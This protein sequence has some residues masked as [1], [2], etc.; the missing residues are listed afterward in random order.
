MQDKK[1][2]ETFLSEYEILCR[3]YQLIIDSQFDVMSIE[4][5]EMVIDI[6]PRLIP[7]YENHE[8]KTQSID[9]HIAHLRGNSTVLS[10]D[11]RVIVSWSE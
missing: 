6:I 1:N 7:E 4:V 8:V 2:K 5:P 11:K 3:K 9:E 10:N